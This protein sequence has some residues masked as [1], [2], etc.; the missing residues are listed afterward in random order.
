ML[1]LNIIFLPLLCYKISTANL[2]ERWAV[3][4]RGSDPRSGNDREESVG[5]RLGSNKVGLGLG[6]GS[7]IWNM[8]DKGGGAP[9]MLIHWEDLHKPHSFHIGWRSCLDVGGCAV[10]S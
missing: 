9:K 10:S 7:R 3:E 2:G 5:F 6:Q 1:L 8:V 4:S